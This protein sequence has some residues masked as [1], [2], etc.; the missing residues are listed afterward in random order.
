MPKEMVPKGDDSRRNATVFGPVVP[1]SSPKQAEALT[2]L[3]AGRSPT[4]AAQAVGVD[5]ATVYRW[6]KYDAAFIA[7]YN[8]AVRELDE[9]RRQGLRL[10]AGESIQVVRRM[11]KSRKTPPAIRA[12]LALEVIRLAEGMPEAG[13]DDLDDAK[14][15]V[16]KALR[17]RNGMAM[18][19]VRAYES[20]VEGL[21]GRGGKR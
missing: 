21:L 15:H 12:R 11:M 7:S 3:V 14:A 4:A 9:V 18:L 16:G 1:L 6:M 8:A 10:L 19:D 13:S 2:L 20:E 5:R 17:Q